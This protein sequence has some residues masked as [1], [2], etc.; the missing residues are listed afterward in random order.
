MIINDVL[1]DCGISFAKLKFHLY[2]IKY[3]LI[4]HI[5]SDH[6]NI[7]TLKKISN[8]FPHIQIIGNYE[9]Y[10]ASD[11]ITTIANAGF[12]IETKDYTFLP[13]ECEHNVLTY[14]YIFEYEGKRIIYATD[15]GSMK[16]APPGKY[17]YFFLESNHCE[18]KV[19]AIRGKKIGNY[20][21]YL[22][23]K[24]H[25]STQQCK[26]FYYMNRRSTDSKLIELHQ[27]N[28]FY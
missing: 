8:Q 14:G 5:H 15:T 12:E 26:A 9:C 25:L 27:S 6:L 28:R 17:D 1:I 19:E 23:A 21:P 20:D 10:Q 2:H 11:R 7:Q 18:N 3:L 4:T 13:F 22:S 16:N 24:R